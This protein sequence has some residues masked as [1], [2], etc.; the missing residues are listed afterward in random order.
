MQQF[1]HKTIGKVENALNYRFLFDTWKRK[2]KSKILC[3]EFYP[4]QSV[5]WKRSNGGKVRILVLRG[6]WNIHTSVA[7]ITGQVREMQ[8]GEMHAGIGHTDGSLEEW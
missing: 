1:C 6:F 3:S 7:E 8:G 2:R 5:W 4:R